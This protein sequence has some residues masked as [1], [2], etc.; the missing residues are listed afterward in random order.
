VFKY[1]SLRSNFKDYWISKLTSVFL[2]VS[3]YL[4]MK[5]NKLNIFFN[6]CRF[7][8]NKN[9][10][11]DVSCIIK[12]EIVFFFF[13]FCKN[14]K[15]N[16]IFVNCS[17]FYILPKVCISFWVCCHHLRKIFKYFLYPQN[18]ELWTALS[19]VD[20]RAMNDRSLLF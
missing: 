12:C 16:H 15:I 2:R 20:F 8:I 1:F 5:I 3:I 11:V 13:L 14:K 19:H 4:V 6:F 18:G 7:D 10:S 17:L 9:V